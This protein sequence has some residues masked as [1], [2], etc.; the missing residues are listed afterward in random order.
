MRKDI[1]GTNRIMGLRSG[2]AH[3]KA[4]ACKGLAQ[5]EFALSLKKLGFT[6]FEVLEVGV[7]LI[8]IAGL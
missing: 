6:R 4:I 7:E 8:L 3:D 1:A 2:P 5:T